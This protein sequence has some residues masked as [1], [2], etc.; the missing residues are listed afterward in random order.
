MIFSLFGCAKLK[1]TA[2][3]VEVVPNIVSPIIDNSQ[4]IPNPNKVPT[5]TFTDPNQYPQK[6][7]PIKWYFPFDPTIHPYT[8]IS[9]DYFIA[10]LGADGLFSYSRKTG[11]LLAKYK[12]P[13]KSG[14]YDHEV[15]KNF[16]LYILDSPYRITCNRIE[17]GKQVWEYNMKDVSDTTGWNIVYCNDE[18]VLLKQ[19][20]T[21]SV[22][23]NDYVALDLHTGNYLWK[24]EVPS[25]FAL[26]DQGFLIFYTE[27]K[28][29]KF[30][31]KTKTVVW[32]STDLSIPAS[33]LSNLN[34]QY[35]QK[36]D[37]QTLFYIGED[38]LYLIN[39]SDGSIISKRSHTHIN[40]ALEE[41]LFE[42]KYYFDLSPEK[43]LTCY[44]TKTLRETWRLQ[45]SAY[46][47]YLGISEEDSTQRIDSVLTYH[48]SKLY[49]SVSL[50]SKSLTYSI[51]PENGKVDWIKPYNIDHFV[52]DYGIRENWIQ[53]ASAW[54]F[55]KS[56]TIIDLKDG[57]EVWNFN[58]SDT[59]YSSYFIPLEDHFLFEIGR[60]GVGGPSF[61]GLLKISFDG[62]IEALYT[63]KIAK[64]GCIGEYVNQDESSLFFGG[65]YKNKCCFYEV[66][67][68]FFGD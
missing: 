14:Y 25:I 16:F 52:H 24:T 13:S 10:A 65:D 28:L 5:F 22:E 3:Q 57:N 56:M 11:K 54:E 20:D 44:D 61:H 31:S 23:F 67:K 15:Y 21:T 59:Y 62:K 34:K 4:V 46:K 1:Q 29:I 36:I 7:I 55:S 30:N 42:Q 58:R 48:Q 8:V 18:V 9:S 66:D 17:D 32:K 64:E 35:L 63:S 47:K 27:G 38:S 37:E 53:D 40:F 2:K 50:E 6:T 60:D 12:M 45:L 26:D 39:A 49:I 68:I 41:Y 33:N 43:L 51:N 19:F